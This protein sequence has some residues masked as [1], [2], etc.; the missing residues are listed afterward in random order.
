MSEFMMRMNLTMV[1]D[2]SLSLADAEVAVTSEVRQKYPA[3]TPERW[4]I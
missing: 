2:A 1:R 4:Q 3:F